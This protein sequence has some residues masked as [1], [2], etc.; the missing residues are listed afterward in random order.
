MAFNGLL[1]NDYKHERRRMLKY[2]FRDGI[3]GKMGRL[4]SS[5]WAIPAHF[6]TH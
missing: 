6:T 4:S 5:H 2:G 3:V 1:V